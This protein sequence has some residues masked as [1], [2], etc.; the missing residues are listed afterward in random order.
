MS[1]GKDIFFVLYCIRFH[2]IELNAVQHQR[3]VGY[4]SI[5]LS[6]ALQ[7]IVGHWPLFIFLIFYTV[8]RTHWTR[9]QFVARPPPA[10]T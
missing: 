10:H 6:M 3:E 7:S 4:L 5:Y 8:G 2:V 9:D 1:K